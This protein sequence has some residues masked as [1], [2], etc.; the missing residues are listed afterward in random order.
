MCTGLKGWWKPSSFL[1]L[2]SD[3][4]RQY[5]DSS[6]RL[7]RKRHTSLGQWRDSWSPKPT[8]SPELPAGVGLAVITGCSISLSLGW[9]ES[10]VKSTTLGPSTSNIM[11]VR[12]IC[13]FLESSKLFLLPLLH[14]HTQT[15]TDFTVWRSAVFPARRAIS[16]LIFYAHLPVKPALLSDKILKLFLQA[17][18]RT[19]SYNTWHESSWHC[20]GVHNCFL[21]SQWRWSG[22]T[23]VIQEVSNRITIRGPLACLADH[24]GGSN[25]GWRE[26]LLYSVSIF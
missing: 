17:A 9:K 26:K 20:I 16:T 11:G 2:W 4:L 8:A 19:C 1:F 6:W 18:K 23:E 12:S 15:P 7:P 10:W 21:L 14:T 24:A 5:D 22:A 25:L 3:Y 13:C